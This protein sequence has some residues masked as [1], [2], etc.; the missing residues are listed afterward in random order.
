MTTRRS[1][2]MEEMFERK[3][4]QFT[5]TV[6][7]KDDIEELKSLISNL[8]EKILQQNKIITSLKVNVAEQ[9]VTISKMEDRI[10]VLSSSLNVLKKKSD[11]Q[12]QYSRRY[13]LR[14]NGI[15]KQPNES[16]EI[17]VEKVIGVCK[18][19]SLDIRHQDIDRA[20]RVGREK[21]CMIVKFFSFN[22]RTALYRAR[23]KSKSVK[24]H[25]DLTKT[26]LDL[27]DNARN[28]L[29]E[30]SN[31]E[32]VFADINCNTVVKLKGDELQYKFTFFDS[33]EK[34]QE[35]LAVR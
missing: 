4:K 8:N 23:K 19:L 34:F 21:K 30:K 12:E 32:F 3:L 20:H 31:V 33:L 24:I 26:R 1:H 25:L 17:C 29:T 28:L 7:S 18:D 5:S 10:G 2:E 27:L 14:I 22:K 35:I 11:D 13:C 16:N 6:A 9:D 15:T